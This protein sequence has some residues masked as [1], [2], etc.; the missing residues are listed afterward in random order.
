MS[1]LAKVFLRPFR[2]IKTRKSTDV[3]KTDGTFIFFPNTYRAVSDVSTS[4]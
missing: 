3:V 1:G 2:E 4:V